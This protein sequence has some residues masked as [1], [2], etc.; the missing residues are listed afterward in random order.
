LKIAVQAVHADVAQ[1]V[2]RKLPKLEVA[3]STP[4]VRFSFPTIKA[5][6][7]ALEF[8]WH[9]PAVGHLIQWD[10][11]SARPPERG[12]S[13]SAP[14]TEF[15]RRAQRVDALRSERKA[16]RADAANGD[17]A[18]AEREWAAVLGDGAIRRRSL[19]IRLSPGNRP[20]APPTMEEAWR[21]PLARR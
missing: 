21:R 14:L 10:H 9:I 13:V 8:H 3:G 15:A 18:A 12:V 19:L 7:P 16:T 1:L 5:V 6:E 17:V 11:G 20:A 4:V 2:E